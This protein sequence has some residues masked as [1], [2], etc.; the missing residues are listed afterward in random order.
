MLSVISLLVC[1]KLYFFLLENTNVKFTFLECFS[2]EIKI[3]KEKLKNAIA[4]KNLN[5]KY[6][7]ILFQSKNI[8]KHIK[9]EI[10]NKCSTFICRG[11]HRKM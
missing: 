2:S 3:L 10:K 6:E 8:I 11:K 7:R 4:N 9:G 5:A 1:V